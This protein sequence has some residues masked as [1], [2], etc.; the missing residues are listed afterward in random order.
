M[1]KLEEEARLQKEKEEAGH[2]VKESEKLE[3]ERRAK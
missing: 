3:A 1:S 2:V